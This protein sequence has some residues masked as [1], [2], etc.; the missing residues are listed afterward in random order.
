MIIPSRVTFL[1]LSGILLLAPRGS[2]QAVTGSP[3]ASVWN[4]LSTPAMDPAKSAHAENVEIVRDRVHITLID[5]TIQFTQPASG[6]V[7]G[8]VF[9]GKGRLQV[10]P[11]NP[12][13]AQQLRL[14]TKQDK[15]NVDFSDATFSFTDGL[16]DEV[17]KQVK[18]QA[19]GP[20]GDDLYA[21]RQKERENLGESALPRLMQ[22]ILSADRTRMAY[23]LADMK[24]SEKSW[25]EVHDDA[26]QP[27]DIEVGR[28][29]DVGPLKIFDTWMSFPAGG[30]TSADAWK[31]PQA[32]EDFAIRSYKIDAEVT[33]GAE[34]NATATLDL[35]P[36][37]AGQR[38][39]IFDLDANLRLESVKDSQNNSLE[40]YQ[41]RETKDRYQSYGDYV[42]V[43]LARPLAVGTPLSLEFRYGGKRAIRKAGAGNYFCESSGWYPDLPN[44]FSTRADFN[45]TFHSPKKSVLVATGEKTSDTVD[46]NNRITTWKSEMPLAVAG[47]AYGDYKVTNDKAGDVAID[48]YANREPDDVMEQVQRYFEQGPGAQEAAVGS[49]SPSIMAK[50][51]GTEI[52]NAVRVFSVWF[53]PFP[54]K[55]LSVTSLPISYSY[56]QGWPGLL[57][58]WSASFLD[59]TQRNAIGIR[60]QTGATDF[61]RG[62]ETS[63]Q[64]WGHRVGWKSYHDQ[65]LSE[66]FAEFS[67]DLYV[68]YRQNMK[69]YLNRWRK[70]KELLR[71]KDIYGHEVESLGPIWMGQRIRSSITNPGSYQDLIYSKGGYVLQMLRMQMMNP[72]DQ[73]P[74]RLFQEMMQ[75]Y[76]K[77][78]DNKAASTEDFKA[79]VEKHM[80][81]GMDLDGN[82]KMDW[83]FNQYVYGMGEPQYTFHVAT[84][85]ST[86]G[87]T[88]IKGEITRAGV[89]DNWKD[90]I[91]LYAHI[92]P[93]TIK[94]GT[95]AVTHATEPIDVIIPGKIDRVSIDDY[96]GLL[97]EVKQ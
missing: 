88:H 46:G 50:T 70:E 3:A 91:P 72:R 65:W 82:H 20:A 81:R 66:G 68:E 44:S 71:I 27:E 4:A 64:W 41:S 35:D 1:F 86:A 80:T 74:D 17:A 28:W 8:A 49:M 61:F 2:A 92:G 60:D 96:E 23:F 85:A 58:L 62:H 84:E 6:V 33:S 75:D 43:V 42:A 53:G 45:L 26:L 10:D 95:V 94:M 51:M 52:A 12:L 30:R 76:C 36:R 29:V 9:H 25:V 57:Y 21:K 97:A 13:E 78:F 7:F 37:R 87:K 40:F 63:H 77:T 24:T 73:N 55:H 16:F 89:P 39:L 22:S 90:A 5:G 19:A 79:I 38:V 59:S 93:R 54:Y 14:F 18:W 11:P 56:G 15:L 31:D 48:I 32:R 67:G 47:F 34:L 83:F 69:E